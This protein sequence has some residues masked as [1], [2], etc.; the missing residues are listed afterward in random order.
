MQQIGITERG[1]ASLSTAWHPWIKGG[2]PAI[3]ITKDPIK[4]YDQLRKITTTFPINVIIH[5][6]IT[7]HGNSIIEP[8]APSPRDALTGYESLI[9]LLDHDRIVLRIDP[10]FPSKKGM[11]RAK[12]VLKYHKAT[13]IRISFL[14]AYPHVTKRFKEAGLKVPPYNFHAPLSQRL[15]IHQELETFAK[16]EIEVC[17]EPGFTCTGCISEKDCKILEV[18]TSPPAGHQRSSCSCL[19]GKKEL[20]SNKGRCKF[21]CLYCYWK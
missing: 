14:D 13:R 7:G 4:L 9:N 19:A 1:D 16:Q 2:N 18:Q 6:T 3:L 17:G 8:N 15:E 5:C 12:Q 11:D 20:L 21:G 10:I